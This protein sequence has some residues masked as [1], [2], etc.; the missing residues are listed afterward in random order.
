MVLTTGTQTE[1]ERKAE[2]NKRRKETDKLPDRLNARAPGLWD[3]NW[4][5]LLGHD[6]LLPPLSSLSLSSC[7]SMLACA[8]HLGKKGIVFAE[9]P[10]CQLPTPTDLR[11]LESPS[12][13]ASNTINRMDECMPL[14]C[15][16]EAGGRRGGGHSVWFQ[17]W[18]DSSTGIEGLRGKHGV[19]NWVT[20][21]P[22]TA[23]MPSWN[24][25]VWTPGRISSHMFTVTFS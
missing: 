3:K 23:E 9:G 25:L 22:L 11:A 4:M 7:S 10:R 2:G 6:G 16:S 18:S 19:R 24:L 13:P 5:L 14:Y 12:P 8:D 15:I 1:R 17:S 21:Q 20:E